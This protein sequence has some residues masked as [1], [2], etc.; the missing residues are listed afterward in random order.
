MS[1]S[2]GVGLAERPPIG[3]DGK[4]LREMLDEAE[5]TFARTGAYCGCE[6][7]ELKERDPIRYE[8]LYARLR[9]GVVSSRETAARIAASPLVEEMGEVCFGLY[10]PEGDSVALS[11]GIIVHVHTMSE[12]IKY[13]VRNDYEHNPGIRDRDIFVN[14]DPQVSNVHCADVQTFVPIFWD[15]ELVGWAAAV[16]HEFD[17]GARTPGGSSVGPIN[18]FE[19]GIDIPAMRCGENDTLFRDYVER[20]QKAVRTPF[21]WKLDE[22]TRITG[23]HMIRDLVL[24]LIS[25]EGIE[26]YK[27]L[28]REAVEEGRRALLER[29]REQLVPGTYRAPAFIDY[30]FAQERSLPPEAAVDGLMHAPMQLT[31]RPDGKLELSLDGASEWGFHSF[32]CTPAA[33]FGAWWALLAETL[34]SNDKVNDGAYYASS[35]YLPVGSWAN[36]GHHLTSHSN[37]W[38]I[39]TPSFNALVRPLSRGYQARGYVEEVIAGWGD[40]NYLQGGSQNALDAGAAIINIEPCCVGA[41]GGIVRDGLDYA[42]ASWFPTGDMGEVEAWEMVEPLLY[43][44]RMVKPNSGGLGRRRGGMGFES[45]RMVWMDEYM[46]QNV[47]EGAVFC[48]AGLFGGYPGA[49]GYRH[50]VRN[51]NLGELFATRAP[52]PIADGDPGRSEIQRLVTGDETLDKRG[53]TMLEPYRRGDLYLSFIKGGPG[54]GDPFERLPDDVELDLNEGVLLPEFA[55]RVYAAVV[56]TSESGYS[57]DREATEARRR[58]A[59]EERARRA[60]PVREWI[61]AERARRVVPKKVIEPLATMY[62]SS[63]ELSATWAQQYREFWRLDEDFTY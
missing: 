32:N 47:G 36:P 58:A 11:T 34:L 25:A 5:E 46:L 35:M 19:D 23:C 57:V 49:A 51:T 9:G 21:F 44:G 38:F 54:L 48:Q 7:L 13:I 39:L 27:R 22:K 53:V 56:T 31:V 3:W 33:V 55:E 24:E 15:G 17:M 59:R 40:G 12:A 4:T 10:T 26:T 50:N 52:Y 45:L 63:M 18:R 28:I 30:Q 8:K 41:G 2:L 1:T 20:C 43:L 6:T 60:I 16:T 62:R 61:E 29:V 37:G 42:S 14:N